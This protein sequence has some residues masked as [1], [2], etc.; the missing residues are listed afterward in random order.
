MYTN[1]VYTLTLTNI[2]DIDLT[3]DSDTK[4]VTITCY[5][6]A[7]AKVIKTTTEGDEDIGQFPFEFGLFEPG[8]DISDLGN[9]IETGALNGAGDVNFTTELEEEGTWTVVE[10]LPDGWVS[11]TDLSCDIEILF[12]GSEGETYT[13]TFDNTEMSRVDLLKLTNGAYNPDKTWSFE[14]YEGPDGFGGTV[15]ASD[16]TPTD[17]AD[18]GLLKFGNTNLDPGATYTVCEQGIPAGWATFWQVDADGD[19]TVDT[20]VVPYNPNADDDP[21]ED[22]GNRCIDIGA[23]SATPYIPLVPGTTL[24][25]QVDNTYPGGAPRTPGYWKNWNRCT[26]GGQQYTAD[27]NGGWEEGYWLIEDVLAPSIGG[28][29]IWDDILDDDFVFPITECADAVLILD[30]RA[31]DDKKKASDPLHNLATHLLAAQLNFGAGA[32]TTEDVLIWALE[33][34][35]LL[36][37]YNF[38]GWGHDTLKKKDPDAALANDLAWYLDSYNNG[39]FCGDGVE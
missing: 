7:K 39:D 2:A 35:E 4:T 11:E 14:L 37:K 18:A 12:P 38:D 24:H 34:E 5:I 6:P 25:F 27:A 28:G 26:G 10:F 3:D 29:I 30:K 17:P 32:C 31:F 19:G 8:A 21:P 20:A 22:V 13:C 9:A 1:G 23:G 36:D 16:S 15:V 33:A